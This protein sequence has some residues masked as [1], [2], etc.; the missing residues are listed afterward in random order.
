MQNLDALKNIVKRI[1]AELESVSKEKDPTSISESERALFRFLTELQMLAPRV[2]E[3]LSKAVQTRR[4][5]VA[6]GE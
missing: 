5:Q 1:D 6:R 4:Q 2:G 3:D